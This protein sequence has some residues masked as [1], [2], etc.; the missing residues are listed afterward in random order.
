MN[1][2]SDQSWD[3]I[4]ETVFKSQEWGKYP[5]EQVIRFVARNF[6]AARD[7]KSVRILDLGCG[8]GACAWYMAREGFSV[9]GIDGSETAVRTAMLRLSEEN[10]SADL[11]VGDYLHLPWC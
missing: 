6:Y 10:L 11:R 3:P 1:L 5:P 9:S 8:T 2:S 7:R 4:W